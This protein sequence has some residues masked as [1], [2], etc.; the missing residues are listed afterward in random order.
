MNPR[1]SGGFVFA[2][3]EVAVRPDLSDSAAQALLRR[4]ELS[5]PSIRRQIRWA[6]Y[7]DVYWLEL[8][9]SREELIPA[10]SEICW[11]KVLQWVFTG[12]LMPSAAGKTGGLQ[13]LMEVAPCRPGHFCGIERRFRAGVTDSRGRSLLEALEMVLGR[14]LPQAKAASGGLLLMEGPDLDEDG[15]AWVARDILCNEMLETW[16]LVPEENLKKNDRFHQERVKYDI[17][18]WHSRGSNEVEK[19]VMGSASDADLEALS[20]KRNLGLSLPAHARAADGD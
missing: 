3:I 19:F 14:P 4:I 7:L 16:T 10:L 1:V 5:H 17:P 6:R 20:R 15:L 13:D 11:D 9:V 12:N 8:P 2:R 18:K